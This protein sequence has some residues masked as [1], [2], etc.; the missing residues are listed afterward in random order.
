MDNGMF[1]IPAPK[2]NSNTIQC[3]SLN[4][5]LYTVLAVLQLPYLSVFRSVHSHADTIR[6]N[7]TEVQST[8]HI[9][10]MPS[11]IYIG[12]HQ[13]TPTERVHITSKGV[14]I[15]APSVKRPHE[16]V[17]LDVQKDEVVKV[18]ACFKAQPQQTV[19]FLYVLNSCGAY[20]RDSLDMLRTIQDN[21]K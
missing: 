3:Y 6:E 21:C 17:P 16:K 15:V 2:P 19:I 9:S 7:V 5:Q 8:V 20:V 18:V 12:T 13:F 10:V 14:R 11:R 4:Q 1:L